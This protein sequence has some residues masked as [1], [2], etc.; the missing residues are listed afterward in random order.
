[1]A[2]IKKIYFLIAAI[3][4]MTFFCYAE[5]KKAP[6]F[7]LTD[8][9]GYKITLS[10]YKGKVVVLNFWASWCPPCRQEIPDFVKTYEAYKDKGL[11]IIG[12]AV[13][14]SVADIKNLLKEYKITYPVAISPSSIEEAYGNI[15]VVP[16]TFLIDKQGNL[17]DK[18]IGMFRE[19]ELEKIV[20]PFLK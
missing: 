8:I 16:T 20:Q 5:T 4:M 6:D 9:N 18:K 14:S 11:I 19:G 17:V 2:I 12:V 3:Y 10:S 7:T 13:N 1:M 15:T